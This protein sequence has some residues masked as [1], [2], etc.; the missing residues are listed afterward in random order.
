MTKIEFK[1]SPVRQANLICFIAKEISLGYY[2]Q[3]HYCLLPYPNKFRDS[4][5]LPDLSYSPKFWKSIKKFKSERLVDEFPKTARDEI[6][7]KT[8][9]PATGYDRRNILK[10]W[11]TLEPK[12]WQIVKKMGIFTK[13]IPKIG[14]ISCLITPFDTAGSFSSKKVRGKIHIE[15]TLRVDR[16]VSDLAWNLIAIMLINLS[17]DFGQKKWGEKQE[18]VNFLIYETSLA[19]ILGPR[20]K[21]IWCQEKDRRENEKYLAKLGFPIINPLKK[22]GE[23]LYVGAKLAHRYLSVSEY[24]V[25]KKLYCEKNI[26]PEQ[27]ADILWRGN[28]EKFSLW[29]ITKLVSRLRRKLRKLGVAGE[30][31]KTARNRGYFLDQ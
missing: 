26:T 30:V 8:T 2:S 12:F 3:Y 17:P 27:I 1:N 28:P 10:D 31:I 11:Q 23:E 14:K 9:F 19:K 18:I 6:L 4:V 7:S 22:V 29:A 16:P 15:M 5:Y 20:P 25:F 24:R 21:E 13:I